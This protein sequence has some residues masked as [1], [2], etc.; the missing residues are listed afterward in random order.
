MNQLTSDSVC[1][2]QVFAKFSDHGNSIK[3]L[4]LKMYISN[5]IWLK[6]IIFWLNRK[7]AKIFEFKSSPS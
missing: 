5:F 7:F 4:Y 2:V 1:H 3:F 6:I